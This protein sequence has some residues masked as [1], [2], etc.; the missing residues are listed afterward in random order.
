MSVG[1]RPFGLTLGLAATNR[2]K[3]S[4]F[5]ALGAWIKDARDVI[6]D[7][8]DATTPLGSS[9]TIDSSRGSWRKV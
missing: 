7:V 9:E 5:D 4:I 8:T 3:C 1:F 2:L 6:W